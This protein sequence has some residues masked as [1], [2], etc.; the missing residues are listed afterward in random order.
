[1][2]YRL[3]AKLRH[4][5]PQPQ[6]LWQPWIALAAVAIGPSKCNLPLVAHSCSVAI[7][8]NLIHNISRNSKEA[9]SI[10]VVEIFE[11]SQG[12]VHSYNGGHFLHMWVCAGTCI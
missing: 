5:N 4:T 1:M 9:E 7:Y 10:Q 8:A 3:Y 2:E 12:V 11:L 6:V